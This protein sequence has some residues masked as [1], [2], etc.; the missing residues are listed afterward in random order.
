[1]RTARRLIVYLHEWHHTRS[2]A[3]HDLLID[4]LTPHIDLET[5]VWM[6]DVAPPPIL[7]DERVAFCQWLPPMSWLQE[8][9]SSVIWL[10][11]WDNQRVWRQR[12]WDALPK[13]LRI[14]AFSEAAAIHTRQAGLRTLRLQFFQDPALFPAASFKR[15]VLLYWN[16][17]GLLSEAFLRKLVDVLHVEHVIF[18]RNIDPFL[19]DIA[20]F[21]LPDRI[22]GARVEPLPV[23][24]DREAYWEALRRT[25]IFIASRAFEGAGSAFIEALASGCAVFAHDAPTMNEYITHRK[26]GMLFANAMPSVVATYAGKIQRRIQ[27]TIAPGSV[28]EAHKLIRLSMRQDWEGIAKLHLEA[29]GAA[30]RERHSIGFS[31]WRNAQEEYAQF[32]LN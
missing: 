27:R 10:P 16:R 23:T 13:S 5:R 29:L 8:H 30:A 15:R 26:D 6:P 9:A 1:M 20:H 31:R 3:F 14:V 28:S 4:P 12:N 17:T 25:N 19:P 2:R 24:D 21:D 11:M 32:V 7:P 18:R 22:G